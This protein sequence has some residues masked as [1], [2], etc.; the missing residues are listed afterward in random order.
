MNGSAFLLIVVGLILFYVVISDKFYCLEGC[1]TCMVFGDAQSTPAT[2]PAVA[3][4]TKLITPDLKGVQQ[5]IQ[6]IFV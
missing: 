3:A 4:P 6:G 2:A 1:F 5:K